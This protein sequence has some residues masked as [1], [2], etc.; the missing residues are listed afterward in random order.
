[1]IDRIV[2]FAASKVGKSIWILASLLVLLWGIHQ[3]GGQ[4][5]DQWYTLLVH[6]SDNL[7]EVVAHLEENGFDQVSSSLLPIHITDFTE[8]ETIPLKNLSNR[9]LKEDRRWDSFLK[10]LSQFYSPPD[11]ERVY[12]VSHIS[13]KKIYKLLSPLSSLIRWEQG[14]NPFF[15]WAPHCLS[16]L[17]G[18]AFIILLRKKSLLPILLLILWQPFVIYNDFY[19]ALLGPSL[20]LLLVTLSLGENHPYMRFIAPVVLLAL[21][22][23]LAFKGGFLL[24]LGEMSLSMILLDRKI[25]LSGEKVQVKRT[26]KHKTRWSRKT[27]DHDLFEPTFFLYSKQSHPLPQGLLFAILIP[28]FALPLLFH[29]SNG[30]YTPSFPSEK[31]LLSHHYYQENILY[32][33]Q[34]YDL[35]PQTHST[36]VLDRDTGKMVIEKQVVASYNQNYI[37]KKRVDL[38]EGF[39]GSFLLSPTIYEKTYD[40]FSKVDFYNLLLFVIIL[41]FSISKIIFPIN[42]CAGEEKKIFNSNRRGRKIA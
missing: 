3:H 29:Y 4:K 18:F 21:G 32:G 42:R 38:G 13:Y 25:A 33:A 36:Y 7:E 15:L 24:F 20:V 28:L 2:D 1:M 30:S 10:E 34:L 14:I 11:G 41:L 40:F 5:K 37:D 8:L 22:I 6:N 17:L 23:I 27:L 12:F 19:I 39:A 31:G 26:F 16:L 9:L 35:S